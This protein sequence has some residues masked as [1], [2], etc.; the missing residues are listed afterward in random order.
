MEANRLPSSRP[1][2]LTLT[3]E[4]QLAPEAL[5]QVVSLTSHLWRVVDTPVGRYECRN[6]EGTLDNGYEEES[7]MENMVQPKEICFCCVRL[8]TIGSDED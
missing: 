7:G 5:V 4:P 1:R 8:V 2:L 3:G 6:L